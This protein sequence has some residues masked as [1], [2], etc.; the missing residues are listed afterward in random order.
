MAQGRIAN[1]QSRVYPETDAPPMFGKGGYTINRK[2][3]FCT[4]SDV[5]IAL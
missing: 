2:L 3:R 5:N 1:W 4:I